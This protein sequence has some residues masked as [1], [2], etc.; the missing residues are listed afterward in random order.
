MQYLETRYYVQ[1]LKLQNSIYKINFSKIQEK[2]GLISF[3]YTIQT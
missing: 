3:Q 2:N 1:D